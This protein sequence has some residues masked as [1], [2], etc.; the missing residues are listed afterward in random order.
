MKVL[1]VVPGWPKGSFWG[2]VGFKFPSLSLAA[3]AAVT[4]LE[5]EVTFADE[6]LES[7]DLGTSVDLVGITAM[8]PQAPRAYAIAGAFGPQAVPLGQHPPGGARLPPRLRVLFGHL[9][10][11]QELSAKAAGPGAR[12]TG[13][14]AA[15]AVSSSSSTTTWPPTGATRCNCSGRCAGWA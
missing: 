9:L 11:R 12:R 14:A 8:T 5:W 7:L 4:P 13:T 6:N 1:L 3:L 2:E 10:F 15:P